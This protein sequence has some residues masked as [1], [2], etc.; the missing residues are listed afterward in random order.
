[1]SE[2]ESKG[3]TLCHCTTVHISDCVYILYSA[4]TIILSCPLERVCDE[5]N[6][7]CRTYAPMFG[8]FCSYAMATGGSGNDLASDPQVQPTTLLFS[9]IYKYSKLNWCVCLCIAIY[10][11]LHHPI[12]EYT[13]GLATDLLTC[14]PC[15]VIVLRFGTYPIVGSSFL[16]QMNKRN[17]FYKTKPLCSL[18]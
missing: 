5:P 10:L 7:S 14:I 3:I 6:P 11:F 9:F 15:Y 8:G 2:E 4:M 1:M 17:Y 16:H 13:R 18:R 12:G